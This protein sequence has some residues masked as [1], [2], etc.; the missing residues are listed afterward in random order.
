MMMLVYLLS[1]CLH[2]CERIYGCM[3]KLYH[4]MLK[5]NEILAVIKLNLFHFW[6]IYLT[7]PL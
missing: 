4:R 7:A 6:F 2:M 5:L 3:F 1:V